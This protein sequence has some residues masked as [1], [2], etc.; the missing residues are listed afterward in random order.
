MWREVGWAKG[1]GGA[2]WGI[3]GGS[4]CSQVPFSR[5]A[6]FFCPPPSL[7]SPHCSRS[8]IAFTPPL[9]NFYFFF[10]CALGASGVCASFE[11]HSVVAAACP[12]SFFFWKGFL[13]V[14]RQPPFPFLGGRWLAP[15]GF[16]LCGVVCG[17]PCPHAALTMRQRGWGMCVCLVQWGGVCCRAT[18]FRGL[19]FS[20]SL[21]MATS[22]SRG[23]EEKVPSLLQAAHTVEQ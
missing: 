20:A 15:V 1:F 12:P 21:S 6:K 3:F 8:P 22:R 18:R 5:F 11:F 16:V 17:W 23:Q 13:F 14:S 7:A 19:R 2:V 9:K 10:C 4:S